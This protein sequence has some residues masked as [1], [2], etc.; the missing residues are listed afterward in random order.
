MH[1]E[2]K[3]QDCG[4]PPPPGE[5]C[6]GLNPPIL[7]T[8]KKVTVA[9]TNMLRKENQQKGHNRQKEQVPQAYWSTHEGKFWLPDELPPPG[10]HRNN[11]CL[12]GL[13]IH[14][15]AYETILKYG[16]GG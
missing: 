10:K 6:S 11:M 4:V 1:A 15:P 13:E 16:T 9:T 12:P 3:Q 7:S 2:K 5:C 14:H 8:D